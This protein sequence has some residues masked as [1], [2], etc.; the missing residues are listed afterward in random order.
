M[1]N[2]FELNTK[3]SQVIDKYSK[4]T[5]SMFKYQQKIM[6]KQYDT[7]IDIVKTLNSIDLEQ[8]SKKASAKAEVKPAP[9]KTAP[10]K[11]AAPVAPKGAVKASIRAAVANK[12]TSTKPA[13]KAEI[14][15]AVANST[16]KVEKVATKPA[17]KK[18]EPAKK[19]APVK[20]VVKKAE[21]AKKA[22]P[23]KPVSKRSAK[24][25]SSQDRLAALKQATQQ[26]VKTNKLN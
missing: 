8:A 12:E 19:V 11:P 3:L 15:A 10:A 7:L 5:E 21:P 24:K 26:A 23:A 13:V 18:D 9:V 1:A 2:L 17:V 22:A 14:I 6:S 20:P 25:S 16:T 4:T